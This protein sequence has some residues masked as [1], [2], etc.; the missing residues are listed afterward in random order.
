MSEDMILSTRGFSY[1][2][3]PNTPPF[4]EADI[5][6]E[7]SALAHLVWGYKTMCCGTWNC[8]S[9][10]E[11]CASTLILN[12]LCRSN[13]AWQWWTKGTG[14]RCILDPGA[15]KYCRNDDHYFWRDLDGDGNLEDSERYPVFI[16]YNGVIH[17]ISEGIHDFD[18]DGDGVTD[19]IAE[20]GFWNLLGGA[21]Y[22]ILGKF[23]VDRVLNPTTEWSNYDGSGSCEINPLDDGWFSN[24]MSV[25]DSLDL[26]YGM[27]FGWSGVIG[28]CD[29]GHYSVIDGYEK[30]YHPNPPVGGSSWDYLF[31]VS[32]TFAA[33]VDT[34][35]GFD[36]ESMDNHGFTQHD[37]MNTVKGVVI[38]NYDFY[39]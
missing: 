13:N 30:I 36:L 25:V 35:A 31:L 24:T 33:G 18:D 20:N 5:W 34:G 32:N 19:E 26:G 27:F 11:N 16:D 38:W 39:K 9:D 7:A 14:G 22:Q 8:C 3:I 17:W 12:P 10:V 1:E 15:G 37:F 4:D 2:S 28:T 29:D 21:T 6:E 23:L